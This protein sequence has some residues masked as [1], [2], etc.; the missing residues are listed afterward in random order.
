MA[1]SLEDIEQSIV[2]DYV[3][4]EMI[5]VIVMYVCEQ[6]GVYLCVMQSCEADYKRKKASGTLTNEEKFLF[7]WYLI[8]SRYRNDVR[9]GLELMGGKIT[10][11]SVMG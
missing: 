4:L 11:V 8:K 3:P 2:K 9:K 10:G 7:A 6:I 1:T 5:Q